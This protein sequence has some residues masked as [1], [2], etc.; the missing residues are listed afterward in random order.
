MGWLVVK[1]AQPALPIGVQEILSTC[2]WATWS[3]TFTDSQNKT[4]WAFYDSRDPKE[5]NR[6]YVTIPEGSTAQEF[7]EADKIARVA[8]LSWTVEQEVPD[9]AT[10]GYEHLPQPSDQQ[11]EIA[12]DANARF[13]GYAA[14]SATGIS[15]SKTDHEPT[16]IFYC[17]SSA[18]KLPNIELWTPTGIAP[19]NFDEY[20]RIALT[21]VIELKGRYKPTK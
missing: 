8:T 2:P 5:E 11:K 6:I 18:S 14:I 4:Y 19:K 1:G 10:K 12:R 20:Y 9:S 7:K 21:A 16:W 3:G 15:Y 17:K 13:A